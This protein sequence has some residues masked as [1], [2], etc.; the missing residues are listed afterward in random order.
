MKIKLIPTFLIIFT[1]SLVACNQHSKPAHSKYSAAK[2][3]KGYYW[4]GW[5]TVYF[6][7]L[8]KKE[9][10]WVTGNTKTVDEF[11]RKN[12]EKG[13]HKLLKKIS[14]IYIEIK[15]KLSKKGSYG[16]LGGFPRNIKVSKVNYFDTM[17][18]HS[19]AN[20]KCK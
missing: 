18:K 5:E 6:V 12:Q 19:Y 9:K 13:N 15:A 10:W 4:I 14:P 11:V 7:E 17:G 3:Y 20:R 16:H 2:T 8:C 1:L